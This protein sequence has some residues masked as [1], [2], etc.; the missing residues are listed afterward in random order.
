VDSTRNSASVARRL[1]ALLVAVLLAAIGGAGGWA[2]DYAGFLQGLGGPNALLY[3]VT[4]KASQ[5]WR[6]D[7]PTVP[8]VFVAIDHGSLSRPDLSALPRA[9]FQP[10]WARLIDGLLDAGARR[11]AF[12]TVFA[13][14][15]SDFQVGNFALPEYDRSLVDTL[16]RGRERIVLGRF[17]TL[18]PAPA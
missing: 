18:P 5:P 15:G 3:D 1:R 12:D 10:I 17:P 8:V 2:S 14:A 7:V 9:L 4:L 11:V 16:A 13:Y 6:R